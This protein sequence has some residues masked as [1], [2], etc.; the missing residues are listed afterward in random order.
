M[1]EGGPWP[2]M[3]PHSFAT[4]PRT[5]YYEILE[6][7]NQSFWI[8]IHVSKRYYMDNSPMHQF[9]LAYLIKIMK[10]TALAI[11]KC[12]RFMHLQVLVLAL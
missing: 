12:G 5:H 9:Q 10:I 7:T 2:P 6:Y 11:I 3:P 1:H 4:M 8:I